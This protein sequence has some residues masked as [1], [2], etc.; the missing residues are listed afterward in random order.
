MAME[1]KKSI[2]LANGSRDQKMCEQNSV[3]FNKIECLL[4]LFWFLFRLEKATKMVA[5]GFVIKFLIA[6]FAFIICITY[7][8]AIFDFLLNKCLCLQ[9]YELRPFSMA[10]NL[11]SRIVS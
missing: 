1:E 7:I 2:S 3:Y 8:S 11:I 4:V 5:F 6:V 9:M 10:E